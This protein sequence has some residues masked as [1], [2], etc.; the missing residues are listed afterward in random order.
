MSKAIHRLGQ[1]IKHVGLSARQFD[2]SIGAGN[3]YTLRM[4]RNSAS[5]GTDVIETVLRE[6][7]QLSVVWLITGEGEMLKPNK[8]VANFD[9]LSIE[10]Q[11]RIEKLIEIKMKKQHQKELKSLIGNINK[12]IDSS[13]KN[14]K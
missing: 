14:T 9:Q 1:F 12:E 5:I 10:K 4:I 6:Y 3:G 2:L 11:Q 13:I 7:P 8:E